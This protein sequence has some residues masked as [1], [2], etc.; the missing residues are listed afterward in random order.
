[1]VSLATLYTALQIA[2]GLLVLV[3]GAGPLN[4]CLQRRRRGSV[5]AAKKL[6]RLAGNG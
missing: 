4:S 5:R 3:E 2:G 6:T 1:M